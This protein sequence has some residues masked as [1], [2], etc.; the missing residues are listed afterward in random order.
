M[1]SLPPLPI[2]IAGLDPA[3]HGS[4]GEIGVEIAAIRIV[5]EHGALSATSMD[6]RVHGAGDIRAIPGDDNFTWFPIR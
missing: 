5:I 2:V 4:A 3:I 6:R 1:R